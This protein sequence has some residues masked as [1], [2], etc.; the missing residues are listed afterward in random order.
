M[1]ENNTIEK[2]SASE[3]SGSVDELGNTGS[4][5]SRENNKKDRTQHIY[6]C[7]T[8]N[9]YTME[10]CELLFGALKSICD[11]LVFQEEIGANGNAHLQGT[12]KLKKRMRLSTLK[13]INGS[14]HWEVTKQITSSIAYCSR[15]N[16]RAGRLFTH[17]FTVDKQVTTNQPYGWQLEVIKII[18]EKPDN[19]S[20]YW[21]YD[22]IGNVGKTSLCKHLVVNYNAIMLC[23]KSNDMYHMLSKINDPTL[24]CVD[25]P[26]SSNEFIN[27]GAIEQIKNGLVFSGKYEGSQLVFDCPHVIVFSN[28]MPDLDKMSRDRWKIFNINNNQWIDIDNIDSDDEFF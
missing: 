22:K 10:Q 17:G 2:V 7:F 12:F 19:R 23:G 25:I 14:I 13:K 8:Y 6:W 4:S 20:I 16:K 15:K 11:W 3:R 18:K 1:A 26:R 5:S 9:N 27:Y 21:F 28:E 24:I